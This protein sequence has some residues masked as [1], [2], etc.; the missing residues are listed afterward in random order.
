MK[1]A[2]IGAG[3]VGKALAGSFERAGHDVT[4]SSAHPDTARAVAEQTGARAAASNRD[5]VRDAEV[6]VLAVP[7]GP[8]PTARRARRRPRRQDGSMRQPAGPATRASASHAPPRRCR[9]VKGAGS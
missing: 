1:I 9:R 2:I 3:N 6:V 5:A 8:C 7:Y 4:V